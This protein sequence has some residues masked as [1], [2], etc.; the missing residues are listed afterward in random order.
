M[1]AAL[2]ANE[3]FV[4]RL[5]PRLP[6]GVWSLSGFSVVWFGGI[7]IPLLAIILVSFFQGRGIRINIDPTFLQYERFFS[8][9]GGNLLVRS[10]RIAGTITVIELLIAFPFAL[11]LAKGCKNDMVR[12]LTFTCADRTVLS[13]PGSARHRLALGLGHQRGGQSGAAGDRR[14]GRAG[15]LADLLRVRRAFRLSRRLLPNHGMADLSLH[16]LDRQ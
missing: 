3:D 12:L 13:E 2:T 8:Y 11:W 10:V 16:Q 9:G 14:G 4:R 5:L 1:A 15:D 7:V 6:A